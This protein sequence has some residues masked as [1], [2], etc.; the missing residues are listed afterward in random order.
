MFSE[1]AIWGSW[2]QKLSVTGLFLR[3]L[4]QVCKKQDKKHCWLTVCDGKPALTE[5]VP[6]SRFSNAENISIHDVDMVYFAHIIQN[7]EKFNTTKCQSVCLKSNSSST[8]YWY[9]YILV[10]VWMKDPGVV[11]K[12]PL[13][14]G[15]P[16][17]LIDVKH[18]LIN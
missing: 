9:M 6:S 8:L 10:H 2:R 14:V 3:Q 4:V 15:R 11:V 1:C 5:V 17:A 7:T 16:T 13:L 12:Y 18:L